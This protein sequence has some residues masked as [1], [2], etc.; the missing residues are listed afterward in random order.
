LDIHPFPVTVAGVV[1]RRAGVRPE[2]IDARKGVLTAD[3]AIHSA[4]IACMEEK[5]IVVVVAH[6][7]IRS[8]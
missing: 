3:I 8:G 7:I 1:S 6:I 4:E 2:E 5:T